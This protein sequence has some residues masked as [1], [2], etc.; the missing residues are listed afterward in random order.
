MKFLTFTL[1]GP[2]VSFGEVERWDHRGTET[3]PTKS[4]VIGLLG[5][6]LGLQRGDEKLQLLDERLHMAAYRERSGPLLTDFQTVQSPTGAILNTM[7]KP[8][9]STIITPKQYVQDAVF[10]VFLYGDEKALLECEAAM[11]HPRWVVSLGRRCCPPS[12]PLLPQLFDAECIADALENHVS[13]WWSTLQRRLGVMQEPCLRCEVEY[14]QGMDVS[15]FQGGY[16]VIRHDAVVRADENRYGDRQV[17]SFPMKRR[18][19]VCT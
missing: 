7:R 17:I 10:Q 14:T 13:P 16:R 5:C 18:E 6:C 19:A 3:M 15:C 11:K 8:R 9:G 4:A 12:V 2:L 1:A